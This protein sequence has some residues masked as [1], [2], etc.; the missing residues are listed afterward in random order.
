MI[1]HCAFKIIVI[2]YDLIKPNNNRLLQANIVIRVPI[3]QNEISILKG[4]VSIVK[5]VDYATLFTLIAGSGS[6]YHV[7]ITDVI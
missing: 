4:I 2:I 5:T 3:K 6:F 7:E 1:F